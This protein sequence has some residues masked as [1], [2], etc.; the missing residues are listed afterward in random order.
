MNELVTQTGAIL[1]K[2]AELLKNPA[3]GGAVTGM[4]SWLKE[5]LGKKSA[6]EKL[7][8]IENNEHNED[9]IN[10]LKSNLDFIL[11]DNDDLQAQLAEK[12]KELDLL[13]KQEGVD[14]S[15]TTNT[16]NVGNNSNPKIVQGINTKGDITIN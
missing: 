15:V 8:L 2:S 9:T 16:I 13:M 12:L 3:I 14:S 5:V 10:S 1:L 4:F 11:E 7:E 6:K